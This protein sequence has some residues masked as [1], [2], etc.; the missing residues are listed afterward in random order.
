MQK[1]I[2]TRPFTYA[3][4]QLVPG[5]IFDARSADARVLL[6]IKKAKAVRDPVKLDQPPAS[7]KQMVQQDGAE[8]IGK[9]RAD[10]EA[11]NI[12]V[13]RRWGAKRLQAEIDKA[14]AG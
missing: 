1:L 4:R 10:A 3:T 14:L 2:A 8:D 7:I 5:D 12:A 9:L 11:L 13:D 6:A